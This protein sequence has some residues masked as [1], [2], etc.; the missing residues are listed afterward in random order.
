MSSMTLSVCDSALYLCNRGCERELRQQFRVSVPT[1]VAV[2]T[3]TARRAAI[4]AER[5]VAKLPLR[6]TALRSLF[7]Y[8]N[9]SMDF[10][11][12]GIRRQEPRI[13]SFF[14]AYGD[15]KRRRIRAPQSRIAGAVVRGVAADQE[16]G[17]GRR[18][19]SPYA[20]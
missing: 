20:P 16:R 3:P 11:A 9:P 13:P 1:A 7:V 6:A 4:A 17:G 8:K 14:I 5:G 19:A 2:G 18:G 12:N 10:C 15:K